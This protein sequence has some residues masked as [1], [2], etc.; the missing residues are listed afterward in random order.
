[1]VCLMVCMVA[2]VL[3]CPA[4]GLTATNTQEAATIVTGKVMATVTRA[5]RLP[6]NAI[7]DEILVRPGDAVDENAPLM[8]Y[9]LQDEAGRLLQ[10]EVTQGAATEEIK[11]QILTLERSLAEATAQRNKARQLS[12]SGLGSR[13]AL[14]RLEGDV[15]SLQQRIELLQA[16]IRK[17]E[18][19][20]AERLRELEY[21]FGQPIAEG[22]Q[23]PPSLVLRSPIRGYVLS[24]EGGLN[25]GVEL[26]EGSAPILVGQLDPVLIQVPV[27]E[28]E[29][30]NIREGDTAEVEIPSLKNRKFTAS[31]SEISWVS[32][33]MNVA[34]PSYYTV[35]LTVPNPEFALKP[36]FK[37]I[38]RFRAGR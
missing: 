13:Q 3:T 32:T 6:F 10:Q 35:E 27:Y 30:G 23:L 12:A 34:N 22:E 26:P 4:I 20:F 15:K 18:R 2:C 1:M 17:N 5:P 21:H 31:V 11:S 38:V 14:N 33:D 19:N 29:L 16:S 28:G 37:A 7:V 36:G 9:H 24:L 25:P 8:R